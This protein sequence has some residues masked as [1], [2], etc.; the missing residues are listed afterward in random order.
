MPDLAER[1]LSAFLA[2]MIR[3][4]AVDPD[5]MAEAWESVDRAGDKEAGHALRCI[6]VEATA[7]DQSDWQAEQRRNRFRVVDGPEGYKP[8]E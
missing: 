6:I 3:A 8:D 1:M 2:Q 4:E 7:P 5:D